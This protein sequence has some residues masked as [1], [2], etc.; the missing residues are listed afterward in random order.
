MH[1]FK[2]ISIGDLIIQQVPDPTNI[3]QTINRRGIIIDV[4]NNISTI[5]WMPDGESYL[6]Q[7]KKTSIMN[8]SLRKMIMD[9][10][11]KHYSV[12]K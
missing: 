1:D 9:G 11:I 3:T 2:N 12:S 7:Y 5:E 10:Y 6:Q 4:S 8:S